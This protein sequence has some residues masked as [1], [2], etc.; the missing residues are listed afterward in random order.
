MDE[1][2]QDQNQNKNDE[3]MYAGKFKSVEELEEGYKNAAKVYQENEDLKQ[4]LNEYNPPNDY[5]VPKLENMNDHILKD[6]QQ[7][8]KAAGL[9]QKQFERLLVKTQEDHTNESKMVEDK[10]K[11]IGESQLATLKDY[12]GRRYPKKIQDDIIKK[13]ALDQE[14]YN[15]I[16]DQR[17]SELN[18]QVPGINKVQ[19]AS[20]RIHKEDV[21]NARAEYVKRPHDKHL[22]E[23]YLKMMSNFAHQEDGK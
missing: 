5:Q 1:Q 3:K 4:K 18:S 22:K 19:P 14:T 6:V 15:A 2:N 21:L 7:R 23:R 16:L 20:Y 17:N 8:A 12:V 10:I 9:N 11:S 13:A